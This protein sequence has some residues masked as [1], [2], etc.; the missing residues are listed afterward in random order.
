MN[1]NESIE[2]TIICPT[3]KIRSRI[4]WSSG[5]IGAY[6]YICNM[7]HC[8]EWYNKNKTYKIKK[9]Q[10]YQKETNYSCEKSDEEKKKRNIKRKTRRL[11]PLKNKKCKFCNEKATE[12]HH[13][14]KPIEFNKFNY[15]CH[16]CHI[17]TNRKC[18]EVTKNK[19]N[20]K[21]KTR[22]R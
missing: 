1:N 21:N 22:R 6:C 12:H 18:K 16:K 9:N 3:C 5:R 17:K 10:N 11:Y 8:R 4:K 2:T 14:T 15:V 13:Y 20:A 7:K 19:E